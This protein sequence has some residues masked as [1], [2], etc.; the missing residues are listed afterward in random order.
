MLA[1]QEFIGL[2]DNVREANHHLTKNLHIKIYRDALQ[3]GT[4]ALEDVYIYNKSAKSP[5]G[6]PI[7]QEA[8][9]LIL[10][11]KAEIVSMGFKNFYNIGKPHAAKMSWS[12]TKA[13]VMDDG[14][15]VV[16]Y[17]YKGSWNIQTKYYANANE[18]MRNSQ[19]S[20]R[21]AVVE[22]LKV[23]FGNRPYAPFDNYPNRDMCYVFE[24]VSPYNVWITPY[25]D[26]NLILLGVVHKGDLR[27]MS[28]SWVD[29]WMVNY[30]RGYKFM[31]PREFHIDNIQDAYS[32][33]PFIQ[34]LRRGLVIKDYKDNRAKIINPEYAFIERLI[35]TA[36]EFSPNLFAS[37]ALSED[38]N[39]IAHHYPQFKAVIRMYHETLYELSK[40]SVNA[41]GKIKN[42]ENKKA[43]SAV[44][45]SYPSIVKS[46]L[47]MMRRKQ[48]EHMEAAFKRIRPKKL[49][50]AVKWRYGN[51]FTDELRK[52]EL[53][54][55][56]IGN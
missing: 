28:D 34:S 1:I 24:Y 16:I 56:E 26:S 13:Q 22:T 32:L 21:I 42:I 10:N 36:G 20:F 49:T 27:E 38:G 7:V 30:C 3:I 18:T 2:F 46:T 33:I 14:S 15:L 8:N 23:M 6:D 45:Q 54:G 19:I 52:L 4:T 31:R 51:K 48:V 41:W 37:I 29:A 17:Y 40:I 35:C 47:F 55:S 53:G 12:N 50:A 44:V 43:F 25:H 11:Q 39:R 9:G 5:P